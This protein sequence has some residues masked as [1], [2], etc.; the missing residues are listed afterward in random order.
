MTARLVL[1]VPP[2]F[3]F[4][5]KHDGHSGEAAATISHQTYIYTEKKAKKASFQRAGR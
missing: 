1:A 5:E 2:G 4:A 3:A